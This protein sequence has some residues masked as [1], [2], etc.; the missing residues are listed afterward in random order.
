MI[1]KIILTILLSFLFITCDKEVSQYNEWMLGKW[2]FNDNTEYIQFMKDDVFI[3]NDSI[4]GS[5]EVQEEDDNELWYYYISKS[6]YTKGY[7]IMICEDI[8]RDHMEITNLPLHEDETI[9]VF[10]K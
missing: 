6:G 5:Y 3:M 9:K 4:Q 8:Y 1:K 10:K 2:T 7:G